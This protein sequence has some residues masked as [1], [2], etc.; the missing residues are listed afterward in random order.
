MT[1]MRS[2]LSL[3]TR[4][5][6]VAGLVLVCSLANFYFANDELHTLNITQ[7]Q[8]QDTTR[9]SFQSALSN[10]P[11]SHLP[12]LRNVIDMKSGNI[13]GDPQFLLD[14]AV[15]GHGKCGTTTLMDWL[16][17]HPEIQCPKEEVLELTLGTPA[18]LISRLYRTFVGNSTTAKSVRTQKR[19]YKSP[20]EIRSPRSIKLLKYLFPKTLLIVG[21]RHPV[22][23]FESMYNFKVQNLP[24]YEKGNYWGSPNDLIG[25]CS[26]YRDFHCVGTAKGLFH[27]HLALLG[28]T[29]NTQELEERYPLLRG[30]NITDTPN[31][32]FLFDVQ[33]LS[34]KNATRALA[35]R[36][37]LQRSLGIKQPLP[38]PPHKKPGNILHP[39][40]QARRDRFK[41]RICDDKY[42]PVR[43][44]LMRMA[45]E[46]S[47]WFRNS[48]FL[49]HPDVTVS[50]RDYF[51][52][53]MATSWSTDPCEV[54]QNKSS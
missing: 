21:I 1:K 27:V 20:G 54:Q 15:V 40:K 24:P 29:K 43:T 4:A 49:D 22:K 28:K 34:D 16:A 48:G 32:V 37:D 52:E 41:I 50:S 13:I 3:K 2:S 9:N 38:E 46:A 10:R 36:R 42:L 47:V 7:Q 12:L 14:F 17:E 26:S 51:E 30:K 45:R 39:N 11:A 44:E 35:F 5:A 23:W 19:G 18:Q 6:L 33:Q 31:P 8:H 53:I 25:K